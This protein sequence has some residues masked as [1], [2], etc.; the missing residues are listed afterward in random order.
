[1]TVEDIEKRITIK[2]RLRYINK[3]IELIRILMKNI[4]D[5]EMSEKEKLA[6]NISK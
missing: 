4:Q 3:A 2:K 1:M 5:D 6:E